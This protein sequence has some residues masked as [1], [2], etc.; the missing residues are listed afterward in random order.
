MLLQI[1][2]YI[3]DLLCLLIRLQF[4]LL[5]LFLLGQLL[6]PILRYYRILVL[7]VILKSIHHCCLLHFL[8]LCLLLLPLN[9]FH[10]LLP[11]LLLPLHLLQQLFRILMGLTMM[12]LKCCSFNCRGWNN[13]KLT[14]KNYIDSLDLCF[15]QEHWL[16]YDNLN[17]VREISPDFLCVGVNGLSSDSLLRGCPY[18]GC[19]IL[20]HKLLSLS[21][22]P[23][24][25]CSNH[26]CGLKICDSSGVSYL[27]IC[28]YMPSD[29][30]T[31]SYSILLVSLKVFFP[32]VVVLTLLLVTSMLILTVVVTLLHYFLTLWLIWAWWFL[33]FVSALVLVTLMKVI[34]VLLGLG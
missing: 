18:G 30:G 17:L 31:A 11:L 19:S 24:H 9:Q 23:L 3:A 22:T 29:C 26:F 14:L 27:L 10:H 20:Y 13:G 34:V 21:V 28:V 5:E 12:P 8:A 2:D 25:S 33:N 16:L 1:T 6:L 4:H 32:I 7:L 15:V